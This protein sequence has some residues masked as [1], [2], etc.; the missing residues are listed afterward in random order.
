MVKYSVSRR[1]LK[2]CLLV[3]ERTCSGRVSDGRSGNWE[4]SLTK[5]GPCPWRCVIR[6]IRGT[7]SELWWAAADFLSRLRWYYTGY[8]FV[9]T[10][11]ISSA[12][13]NLMHNGIGSQCSSWRADLT[14]S[15]GGRPITNRT[16]AFCT[17]C[18][19][20]MVDHGGPVA[21]VR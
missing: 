18:K 8:L 15:R 10:R 7:E 17:Q 14:W 1:H 12:T 9:C 21:A 13:L 19:G 20:L 4:C 11:N 2:Q 6:A 3:A 5:L 16:A